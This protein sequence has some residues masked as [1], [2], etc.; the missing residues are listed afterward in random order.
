[1]ILQRLAAACDHPT[2]LQFPESDYLTGQA[3]IVR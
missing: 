3:L 1:M 2:T